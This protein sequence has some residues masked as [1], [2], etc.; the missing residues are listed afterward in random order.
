MSN[1]LQDLLALIPQSPLLVGEVTQVTNEMRVVTLPDGTTMTV[2]GVGT[3]GQK[4]FVKGGTIQ[5]PAPALPVVEIT[6]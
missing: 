6:L 4:V 5:G 2:H 3:V 1:V